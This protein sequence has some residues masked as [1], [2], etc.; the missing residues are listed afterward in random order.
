[1]NS[2]YN[3]RQRKVS[4]KAALAAAMLSSSFLFFP[5]RAPA[6]DVKPKSQLEQ[7]LSQIFPKSNLLDID[8]SYAEEIDNGEQKYLESSTSFSGGSLYR[9][10]NVP[11]L[12]FPEQ[13]QVTGMLT[14]IMNK[15]INSYSELISLA[16]DFSENQKLVLLSAIGG[17]LGDGTYD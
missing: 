12:T 15:K 5:A 10:G 9:Q 8:V 7:I 13:N 2:K 16:K 3:N 14:D 1:M 6:Q 11:E 17:I 4:G